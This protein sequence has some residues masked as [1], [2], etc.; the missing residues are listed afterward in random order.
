MFK[1]SKIPESWCPQRHR[2]R[3][4]PSAKKLEIGYLYEGKFFKCNFCDY[5]A[6][7]KQGLDIKHIRRMHTING[8]KTKCK[9]CEKEV[10]TIIDHICAVH[11][12][13][14]YIYV[15]HVT[16][17]LQEPHILR[18]TLILSIVRLSILAHFMRRFTHKR[19]I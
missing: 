4:N 5:K 1:I 7:Y 19:H 15:Q 14:K 2:N 3:I 8:D 11:K 10:S 17:N 6:R 16:S 9:F 13:E 18:C 12:K